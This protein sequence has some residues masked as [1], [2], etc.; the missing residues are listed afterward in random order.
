MEKGS[1]TYKQIIK[2]RTKDS[3]K[4]PQTVEKVD[5]NGKCSLLRQ[6][7]IK[8][9][10]VQLFATP[11]VMKPHILESLH[12]EAGHQGTEKTV[13]LIRKRCYWPGIEKDVIQWIKQC[14]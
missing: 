2:T 8:E 4:V 10:K 7:D 5:K 13:A 3:Q 9:G 12:N 11:V 1:K 14:E 6:E